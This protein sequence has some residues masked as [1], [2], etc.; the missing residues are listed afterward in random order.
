MRCKPPTPGSTTSSQRWN[1]L[2]G[3]DGSIGLYLEDLLDAQSQL[4]ESNFD[5]TRSLT[6]YNLSR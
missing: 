6:T 3:Q 1:Y 4:T 2:P 5:F